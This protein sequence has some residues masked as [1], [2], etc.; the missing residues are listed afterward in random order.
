VVGLLIVS[1]SAKIAEGVRDLV[2][3]VSQ[4]R[5]PVGAAPPRQ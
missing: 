1:H 2:E 3:Q 5:V 4:G